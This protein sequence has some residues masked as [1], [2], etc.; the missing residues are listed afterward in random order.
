MEEGCLALTEIHDVVAALDLDPEG[1]R[2]LLDAAEARGIEVRDDCGRASV[3]ASDY[4]NGD[5]ATATTDALQLFFQEVE[6]HALLTAEEEVELAR[7]IERGDRQARDRMVTANLRLVVSIARRYQGM[8]LSLL[9]LIQEGVLGLIRAV[10]KFEWQRGYKF[11][12]YAMWWIRQGIQR[13]LASK[14]REIRLPENVV[15]LERRV[16]RVERELTAA[17]GRQPTE[18][19]IA[20]A[21][22]VTPRQLTSLR[23]VA[24]AVTSLD[25]PVGQEEDTP[26]GELLPAQGPGPEEVVSVSLS[27]QTLREAVEALPELERR[28]VRLRYGLDDRGEPRSLREVA[29]ELGVSPQRVRRVEIRALERL[30]VSR[31][32]QALRGAA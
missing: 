5:M 3:R 9:D 8:G 24:R 27:E 7:W 4:R 1:A 23:Q 12:T 21:A 18:D 19:E 2:A 11:S 15:E 14:T 17:L 31:E 16:L 20:E 32:V 30:A 6:R 22:A 29:R 10:D 28:V 13:A 26:L 25:R